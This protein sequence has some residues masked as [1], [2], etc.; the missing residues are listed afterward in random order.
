MGGR[1][2]NW[3]LLLPALLMLDIAL[4][5]NFGCVAAANSTNTSLNSNNSTLDQLNKTHQLQH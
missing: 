3:K 1:I 5:M 2:M 4:I